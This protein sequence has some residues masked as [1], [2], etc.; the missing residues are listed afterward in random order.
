[1]KMKKLLSIGAIGLALACSTSIGASAA[2]VTDGVSDGTKKL[3]RIVALSQY[4]NGKNQ[5]DLFAGVKSDS[6]IGS[7][8]N[9]TV[10]TEINSYTTSSAVKIAEKKYLDNSGMTFATALGKVTTDEA[11]FD[12]FQD[13]AVTIADKLLDMDNLKGAD[14]EKPEKEIVKLVNMYNPKLTVNFG[15]DSKGYTSVFVKESGKILVQINS[16]EAIGARNEINALTWNSV[17]AA[18]ILL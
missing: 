3:M 11:T 16:D 17:K 7:V 18:K 4:Q 1:M 8:S 12:R 14:R 10:I 15:K 13:K 6:A 2:T 5:T 9:A